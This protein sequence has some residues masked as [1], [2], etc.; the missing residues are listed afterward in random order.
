MNKTNLLKI[1][2]NEPEEEPGI[3]KATFNNYTSNL[4][5]PDNAITYDQLQFQGYTIGLCGNIG[6]SGGKVVLCDTNGNVLMNKRP[7]Y[8]G[9]EVSV[10]ALDIDENGEAYGLIVAGTDELVLVYFNNIFVQ[11]ADNTYDITIKK[12]YSLQTILAEIKNVEGWNGTVFNTDIKKSPLGG[13]FLINQAF[14]R[15]NGQYTLMTILLT[16]NVGTNNTYE[17][18]VTSIGNYS[19]SWI[20]SV[21]ANWTSETVSYTMA[22]MS[23][24]EA[25]AVR[26]AEFYKVT[27]T[28]ANTS[29]NTVSLML[30]ETAYGDTEY[31]IGSGVFYTSKNAVIKDDYIYFVAN[32]VDSTSNTVSIYRFN[33]SLQTIWSKAGKIAYDVANRANIVLINNQ[34]WAWSLIATDIT[35][36]HNS[37]KT[38]YFLHITGNTYNETILCED[39][40]AVIGTIGLVQ[41]KFNLYEIIMEGS[42]T[43][44]FSTYIYKSEGY[45]GQAYFSD[46]S[47][48][49]E[50]MRLFDYNNKPIFDRNL[51][52]KTLIGNTINSITQVPY[53]Y[54]NDTPI[55][56]EDLRAIDN[57]VIDSDREEITKNKYEELYI[58]NVDSIKVFDNNNGSKY[59]QNSSLEVAKNIYNGFEDNYKITKY[60][61]NYSDNTN[62]VGDID[63]TRVDNIAEITIIVNN[64]GID[65][66]ELL[67]DDLTIP[68]LKINLE[69]LEQDKIYKIT[70]K[71]KVE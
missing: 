45:N 9:Q 62:V 1:L 44:Y 51:Y 19:L 11:T 12:G 7:M 65:S 27:G 28:F 8:K 57:N 26:G 61:I 35:D 37:K 23:T 33:T 70:Q 17:Y 46:K 16:V 66:I 69:N 42:S 39:V 40:T 60:R 18:K 10:T 55:V 67:N 64:S 50:T 43:G 71:L 38:V 13:Q 53:N 59:N 63:Y 48:T 54:L 56:Q 2:M 68:F 32:H 30:N 14:Q 25:F 41:N 47:V 22:I 15:G 3:N 5:V 58:T 49:S 31:G 6:S 24:E 29:A 36:P 52:N 20:K 21:K 34:I 4:A